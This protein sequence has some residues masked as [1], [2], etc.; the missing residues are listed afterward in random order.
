MKFLIDHNIR[1]QAKLLLNSIANQGWLD[2]IEIQ[3]VTFEEV[4]LAIDSSD[5]EVWR[6]AQAN[7]MI[8]LTANR[9]AKGESSLEQ[10]LREENTP[11]SLPTITIANLDRVSESEYRERCVN[12][13]IEIALYLE[14]YL[15]AR[16]LLIP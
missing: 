13:L 3:F 12:R 4:E 8:L 11:N 1:G 10:V 15:G 7:Q 9:S 2:I 14:N 5:R 16:R 6:L